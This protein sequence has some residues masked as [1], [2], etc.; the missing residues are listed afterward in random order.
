MFAK[1]QEIAYQDDLKAKKHHPEKKK[2]ISG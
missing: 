1:N 2:V